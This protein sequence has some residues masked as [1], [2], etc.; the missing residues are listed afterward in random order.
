MELLILF[1]IVIFFLFGIPI[2]ISYLIFQ[3]IKKME[4]DKLYKLLA[5]IPLIIVGYFIYNAIY[6]DED[7]YKTDFKEVTFMAFPQNG[8]ILYKTA[9]F[10]DQFGDYTSSFLAEFDEEYIKKLELNLNTKNFIRK[11]NKMSS[12]ELDYIEKRKGDIKYSVQYIKDNEV[13]KYF[14]IGFLNDKKSVIIT[15]V[16]W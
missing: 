15:R 12:N 3:W 8:T 5:L 13:G 6:P 9:S 14:S 4:F 16:S 10:P 2:G 11:E 1:F 7:F